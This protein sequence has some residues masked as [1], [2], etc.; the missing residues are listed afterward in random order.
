MTFTAGTQ[1]SFRKEFMNSPY[2]RWQ[3]FLNQRYGG[4]KEL[5]GYQIRYIKLLYDDLQLNCPSL[6][7][8]DLDLLVFPDG[9]RHSYKRTK[10]KSNAVSNHET[11]G[12][13]IPTSTLQSKQKTIS[14]I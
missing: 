8:S 9:V 4:Y 11:E 6:P 2:K 14:K 1:G 12:G 10:H 7:Y 13:S 5:S 3:D